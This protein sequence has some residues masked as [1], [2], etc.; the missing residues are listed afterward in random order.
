VEPNPIL[1]ESVIKE[2]K[3]VETTGTFAMAIQFDH[4]GTLMLEQYTAINNGRRFVIAAQF[5]EKDKAQTRWLAAPIVTRRIADGVLAFTP[6]AT[7]D[8]AEEIVRGINN[9]AIQ[10][11]NQEK[12]KK[13]KEKE[14]AKTS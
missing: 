11:G 5:G 4:S 8:E 9:L 3:I 1:N 6:D 2:A 7:R 13:S 10:N 14:K 12:P